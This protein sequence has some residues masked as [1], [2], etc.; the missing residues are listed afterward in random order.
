MNENFVKSFLITTATTQYAVYHPEIR[1]RICKVKNSSIYIY[2]FIRHL[3]SHKTLKNYTEKRRKTN[4]SV[5]HSILTIF[6]ETQDYIFI[7]ISNYPLILSPYLW[8]E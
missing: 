6:A 1:L 4:K 2:N 7:L 3:G 8:S 5:I